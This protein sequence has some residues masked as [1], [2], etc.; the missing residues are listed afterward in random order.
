MK[1][2]QFKNFLARVKENSAELK[3][4]ELLV[5]LGLSSLSMYQTIGNHCDVKV[6]I[7]RQA[8]IESYKLKHACLTRPFIEGATQ[9]GQRKEHCMCIKQKQNIS[10]QSLL[11]NPSTVKSSFQ[12]VWRYPFH[13]VVFWECYWLMAKLTL[14][15]LVV[16]LDCLSHKISLQG[17]IAVHFYLRNIFVCW[18]LLWYCP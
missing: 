11:R 1:L 9:K 17:K 13:I 6:G 2:C 3:V 16:F 7:D 12:F 18:N 15:V 10:S 8:Y 14:C 4:L 5:T